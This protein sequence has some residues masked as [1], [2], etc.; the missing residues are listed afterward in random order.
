MKWLRKRPEPTY[1]V[2]PSNLDEM[3]KLFFYER[4]AWTKPKDIQALEDLKSIQLNL[5]IFEDPQH[6]PDFFQEPKFQK[7]S[8]YFQL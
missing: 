7:V 2:F 1:I 6:L 4:P 5:K 8:S 3:L